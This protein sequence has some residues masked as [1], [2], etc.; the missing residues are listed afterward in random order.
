MTMVRTDL[1][2]TSAERWP[3]DQSLE[4]ARA[5][6]DPS[7]PRKNRRP[8]KV[9]L[10]EDDEDDAGMVC[11]ILAASKNPRWEVCHVSRLS[12]LAETHDLASYDLTIAD[13][14][15]PDSSGVNTIKS[16]TATMPATPVVALSGYADEEL[17]KLVLACG[18]QDFVHK[19]GLSSD[20]FQRLLQH[21]IERAS[22]AHQTQRMFACSDDAM[23]LL[24]DSNKIRSANA[25]A[26]HL[27]GTSS[28]VLVG[29]WL[30]ADLDAGSESDCELHT[31]RGTRKVRARVAEVAWFGDMLRLVVLQD[32]TARERAK[33]IAER[34][35]LAERLTSVASL[36]I[37][38]CREM[39][40]P[41]DELATRLQDVGTRLDE[42]RDQL[43]EP[44]PTHSDDSRVELARISSIIDDCRWTALNWSRRLPNPRSVWRSQILDLE[45]L[46][47]FTLIAESKHAVED[48]VGGRV[49]ITISIEELPVV[50]GDKT[51]IGRVLLEIFDDLCG[52]AG[53]AGLDGCA[54][55]QIR[56]AAAVSGSHV[57][58]TFV[59][60]GSGAQRHDCTFTPIAGFVTSSTNTRDDSLESAEFAR[61]PSTVGL[62]WC[63][64]IM[65]LH[66]GSLLSHP[67]PD[68][69]TCSIIS[70]TFPIAERSDAAVASRVEPALASSTIKEFE[71]P[72]ATNA[73]LLLVGNS[74][75]V[76]NAQGS[77]L[78]KVYEIDQAAD[79]DAALASLNASAEYDALLCD[80]E[81]CE[82]GPSNFLFALRKAAPEL[83]ERLLV[84]G[85]NPYIPPLSLDDTSQVGPCSLELPLDRDELL[86]AIDFV[87]MQ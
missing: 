22:W 86:R 47:V 83:E 87:R 79:I 71:R 50:R 15:L 64:E 56:V 41:A 74:G 58:I 82:P 81:L 35:W 59:A 51:E 7:T 39:K 2:E 28:S 21:A 45:H 63:A 72:R 31:S 57:R 61:T 43:R 9:L 69:S 24:D 48:R 16:L 8:R 19:D 85:Y 3:R 36:A 37:D 27:F 77:F 53:D 30:G 42:L 40:R 62:A 38:M 33:R 20:S 84:L 13:L 25:K 80:A 73:R 10:I 68:E 23:I 18:A 32:I 75:G 52:E 34:R 29:R 54:P 6:R 67:S 66:G 17:G 60:H 11:H 44:D 55:L 14:G 4:F 76:A 78:A 5:P 49:C 12:Q 65:R 70:I 1:I 46:D 26:A